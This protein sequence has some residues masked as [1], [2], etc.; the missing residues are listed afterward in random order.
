MRL[1]VLTTLALLAAC[2]ELREPPPSA[3]IPPVLSGTTG[4]P[5]RFMLAEATAAFADGGRSMLG[6]PSRLARAAGQVEI[7]TA[8]LARDPRWA[9]LPSV[10]GLEMRAARTELRAALGTRAGADP[11]AVGRALAAAHAALVRDDRRTAA[12]ALDPALFEP[13]GNV[14]L[15]RLAN[16]GPLAQ[17]RIATALAQA[18]TAGLADRRIG[19]LTGALDPDAMLANPQPGMRMA[20]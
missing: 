18:E 1:V 17:A 20:R 12:A 8:E 15:A 10:V 4:D 7:V 13:G 3:R 2:A 6:D 9:P 11:Y 19:G 5:V 16:P 14:V